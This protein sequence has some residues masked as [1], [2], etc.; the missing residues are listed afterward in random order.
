[1]SDFQ[2]QQ[3]NH[4]SDFSVH[5]KS[6]TL[7]SPIAINGFVCSGCIYPPLYVNE[8]RAFILERINNANPTVSNWGCDC[9]FCDECKN[10]ITVTALTDILMLLDI[11][12]NKIIK[13]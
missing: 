7:S 6:K 9:R 13:A 10:T 4:T 12:T 2:I 1:M 5:T 11:L 3:N 8:L